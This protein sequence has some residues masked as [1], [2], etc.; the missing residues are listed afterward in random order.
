[1]TIRWLVFGILL[2][3]AIRP[4]MGAGDMVFPG[5]TWEQATP[6][7]RGV[8]SETLQAAA[9]YL[10]EATNRGSSNPAKQGMSSQ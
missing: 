9:D 10:R 1:M 2:A 5:R 4:V 6:E 7:S 3:T 8:D